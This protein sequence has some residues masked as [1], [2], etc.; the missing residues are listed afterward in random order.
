MNGQ[1]R[2][3]QVDPYERVITAEGWSNLDVL[4]PKLV[5]QR[6]LSQSSLV[7]RRVLSQLETGRRKAL[8]QFQA[9]HP[10]VNH[11]ERLVT[12]RCYHSQAGHQEDVIPA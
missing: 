7:T 5:T 1:F 10:V 12:G 3:S 11:S 2:F 9:G 6:V 8:S 4:Q